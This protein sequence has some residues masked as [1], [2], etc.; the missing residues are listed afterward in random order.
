MSV[1]YIVQEI[2]ETIGGYPAVHS[3]QEFQDVN[4]ALDY[5][6]KMNNPKKKY[7]YFRVV[8]EVKDES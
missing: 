4:Q 3:F 7:S 8:V 2:R 5:K 1:V 6:N